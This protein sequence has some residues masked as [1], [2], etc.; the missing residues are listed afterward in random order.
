MKQPRPIMILF[1]SWDASLI[2]ATPA[3]ITALISSSTDDLSGN[4]EPEAGD[5]E[6]QPAGV[7]VCAMV[8]SGGVSLRD[9]EWNHLHGKTS[10]NPS[11]LT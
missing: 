3:D 9:P 10:N 2:T 5:S 7:M 11:S 4:P 8:P 6:L 1:I